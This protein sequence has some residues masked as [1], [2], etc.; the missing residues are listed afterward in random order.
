MFIIH[1]ARRCIRLSLWAALLGLFCWQGDAGAVIHCIADAQQFQ[2]ALDKSGDGGE[3]SG[4]DNF[5][6]LMARTYGTVTKTPAGPFKYVNTKS[7]GN[8]V[9]KGGYS[10]SSCDT[11]VSDPSI[12][13]LSGNFTDQVLNLT[14]KSA[15]IEIMW[16]TV[17]EGHAQDGAG[18]FVNGVQGDNGSVSLHNT[19]IIDNAA[20]EFAGG[21]DLASGGSGTV[22]VNNNLFFGNSAHDGSGAAE[23]LG[24]GAGMSFYNNT[25]YRNTSTGVSAGGVYLVCPNS[26]TCFVGN[27]ILWNNT[28][29]DL[30]ISGDT[31]AHGGQFLLA[32][33]DIADSSFETPHF[34]EVGTLSVSPKFVS[35]DDGNYRLGTGS[36]LLGASPF[37]KGGVDLDDKPY[38]SSGATDIGAYADT[39]YVDG[40]DAP[41]PEM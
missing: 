6:H 18:I 8:L 14:S 37:L 16:V 12:T 27:N 36:A 21:I 41:L 33:N 24:D 39:I 29:D 25:V 38:P 1:A 31:G 4:K 13:I 28:N 22:T 5:I 26:V 32:Y 34:T 9:I 35:V 10:G 2:N 30:D 7:T 3:D 23:V 20:T 11:Q 40:F 15:S 17:S 19:I